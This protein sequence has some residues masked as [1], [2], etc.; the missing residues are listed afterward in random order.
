[1]KKLT[2]TRVLAPL[3]AL[4]FTLGAQATAVSTDGFESYAAGSS[5]TNATGW[6]FT[7]GGGDGAPDA[8]AVTAYAGA[9]TPTDLPD[10]ITTAGDNFLKLSTGP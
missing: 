5:V 10:G 2:M 6:S 4:A 8:S 9:T 1:M 3:A 7:A